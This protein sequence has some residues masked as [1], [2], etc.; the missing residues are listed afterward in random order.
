MLFQELDKNNGFVVWQLFFYAVN[1]G[2]SFMY[3]YI[4]FGYREG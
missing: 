1:K 3:V 2:V 4:V